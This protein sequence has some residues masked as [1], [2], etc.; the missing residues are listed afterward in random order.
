LFHFGMFLSLPATYLFTNTFT[1][2][3]GGLFIFS[4]VTT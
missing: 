1:Y 3:L 4:T 2:D